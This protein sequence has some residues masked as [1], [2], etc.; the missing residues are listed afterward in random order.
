MSPSIHPISMNRHRRCLSIPSINR[1]ESFFA[2]HSKGIDL[3]TSKIEST[4]ILSSQSQ[5]SFTCQHCFNSFVSRNALFRHLRHQHDNTRQ[6]TNIEDTHKS[7]ALLF[8]YDSYPISENHTARL[9]DRFCEMTPFKSEAEYVG[10]YI[11]DAF[12]YALQTY[13]SFIVSHSTAVSQQKQ[14]QQQ[15]EPKILSRT[16]CTVPRMRHGVLFQETG[17]S[18]CGDVISIAYTIPFITNYTENKQEELKRIQSLL[19]YAN[20]YLSSN[21][22]EQNT[23]KTIIQSYDHV[24]QITIHA[25]SPMPY[26]KYFH[27]EKACK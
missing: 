24:S 21:R 11:Q 17:C 14:Q 18:S 2:V 10:D 25:A 22:Y 16:Q 6:P 20:E 15:D 1:H 26:R 7:V 4:K 19:V 5:S 3:I 23:N 9:D 8:A 27:T 13:Y 12:L